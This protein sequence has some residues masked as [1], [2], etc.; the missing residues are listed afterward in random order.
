MSL[1]DAKSFIGVSERGE[2]DEALNNAIALAK[3]QLTTDLVSWKLKEISGTDGG[4]LLVTHLVVKIE[5]VVGPGANSVK[6]ASA[7]DTQNLAEVPVFL[8]GRIS[9]FEGVDFCQDGAVYRLNT[10]VRQYR[11]KP[12]K[13]KEVKEILEIAAKEGRALAIAGYK[14]FESEC[15]YIEVYYAGS[16][17]EAVKQLGGEFPRGI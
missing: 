17:D 7:T 6:S 2:I 16:I 11:L 9:K 5:A 1:A 8:S 10:F 13:N 12:G 14:R 4:F 15:Q 3:E